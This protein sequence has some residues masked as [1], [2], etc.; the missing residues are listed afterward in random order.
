MGY[1]LV[2]LRQKTGIAGVMT[3]ALSLFLLWGLCFPVARER[4]PRR[5]AKTRPRGSASRASARRLVATVPD[6]QFTEAGSHLR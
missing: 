6:S 5:P 3:S 4:C 2:F 1:V